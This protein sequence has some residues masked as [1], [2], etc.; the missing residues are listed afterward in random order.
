M[1]SATIASPESRYS[2]DTYFPLILAA[3]GVIVGGIMLSVPEAYA[4]DTAGTGSVTNLGLPLTIGS[5]LLGLSALS[6]G[7]TGVPRH[8]PIKL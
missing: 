8:A 5:V 7:G 3:A 1:S 2:F 4:G 6:V